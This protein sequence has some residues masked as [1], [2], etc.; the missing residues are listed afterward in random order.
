M[1]H[2]VLFQPEIPP[3]TGN[4]ARLCV[5][6]DLHLHIIHPIGFSLQKKDVL[7]AGLDYWDHLTLSEHDSWNSFKKDVSE[8]DSTSLFYFSAKA[9]RA[10]WDVTYPKECY[11]IFGSETRGLPQNIHQDNKESM[12]TIPMLGDHSRCLNLASSVSI[13]AYEVMRQ[14][15]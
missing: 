7:R 4:I 5:C 9:T 10:Y 8:V 15:S 6:N 3:N 1:I 2:I 11:I 14:Q 12:L 13:A